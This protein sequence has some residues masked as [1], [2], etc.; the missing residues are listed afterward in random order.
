MLGLLVEFL[1]TWCGMGIFTMAL[2]WAM[3]FPRILKNRAGINRY[4]LRQYM[5]DPSVD[6][7]AGWVLGT[8]IV[9]LIVG[10]FSFLLEGEGFK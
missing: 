3:G 6:P 10:P 4:L 9:H 8:I 7:R 5:E 2:D 1:L